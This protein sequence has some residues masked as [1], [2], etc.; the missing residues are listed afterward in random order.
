M[1]NSIF[2]FLVLISQLLFSQNGFS[3]KVNLK[4][5]NEEK[6]YLSF[7]NGSLSKTTVV[8]SASIAEKSNVVFSQKKKIIGAIYRLSFKKNDKQNFVNINLENNSNLVFDLDNNVLRSIKTANPLNKAFLDAQNVI[9]RD[10]RKTYLETLVK[11]FP[12]S[13]AALYAKL[14]IKELSVPTEENQLKI[15]RDHFFTDLDL[16]DKRIKLLP[17]IYSSLYNYVKLLPFTNEN[18]KSSI[19]NLLRNQNCKSPNYIFYLKWIFQNLEYLNKYNLN[20][21]FNYVFNNY[22]NTVDCMKADEKFY[23]TTLVKL[24]QNEKL[25]LGSVIPA[26]EMTDISGNDIDISSIYPQHDYTMIIFFDPDCTHCQ[27]KMPEI[28]KFFKESKFRK[29]VKIVAFLNT[30][31]DQHWKKFVEDYQMQDWLNVKSKN[32]SDKYQ[33]ELGVFANPNYLLLNRKGEVV[34]KNFHK[35]EFIQFFQ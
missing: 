15:Y 1:K 12:T 35:E 23:Q 28:Q 7:Y 21:T 9:N 26:F 6:L 31:T 22:L 17:N 5:I 19:D 3:V 10:E 33:E 2:I 18:Y 24:K 8:D 25:P 34:L 30:A 32:N 11:K 16:N 20:D 4:N 14:E 27:E 13:A 29:D